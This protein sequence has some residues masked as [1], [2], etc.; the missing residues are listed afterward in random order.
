MDVKAVMSTIGLW[1]SVLKPRVWH[2]ATAILFLG[3]GCDDFWTKGSA[4][5]DDAAM[6]VL[7]MGA[8]ALH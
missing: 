1:T 7:F 4:W 5:E 3:S 6:L 2:L 8:L